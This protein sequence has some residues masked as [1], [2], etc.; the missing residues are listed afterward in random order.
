MKV[1]VVSKSYRAYLSDRYF[2]FFVRYKYTDLAIATDSFSVE[3]VDFT[4]DL[5]KDA[6]KMFEKLKVES[7]IFFETLEPIHIELGS[8][9]ALPTREIIDEMIHASFLAGVGPMAAVAGAVAQWVGRRLVER[10]CVRNV[11][12]ENGGDI[13][14]KTDEEI[15]IGVFA[16]FNS[17]FN[18]IAIVLPGGEYGVCTSSGK[19]GHS[20]SFGNADAVT[21]I[22]TNS[23]IADAFATR[24]GNMVK[25][26]EDLKKVTI[27][28][29]EEMGGNFVGIIAI[30][31]DKIAVAGK[32]LR[33][34][35]T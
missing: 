34:E 23:A 5:L 16:N 18:R 6:Y 27:L 35:Q 32:T 14:L 1:P 15:K 4:Y 13:Y 12:V 25:T 26:A 10:F 11:I 28:A 33:L 9:F 3:M 2:R 29:Q 22:S 31:D 20:L 17:P 8:N 24:Y 30:L 21:V 7:S 19:I